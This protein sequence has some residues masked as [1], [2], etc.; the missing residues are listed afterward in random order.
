MAGKRRSAVW[1]GF[2]V[3]G[4][5]AEKPAP[6][7]PKSVEPAPTAEIAA[8]TPDL[9]PVATPSGVFAVG[10][11]SR[12]LELSDTILGW[13]GLP[14]GLR[15]ILPERT[16]DLDRAVAWDA[17]LE[18]ALVLSG[19]ST[20]NPVQA[21]V[22][23]G[24]RSVEA[25]KQVATERGYEI[26][27]LAPGVYTV[28]AIKGASCAIAPALG[29]ASARLVCAS[30]RSELEEVVPY[31]TRGLPN[32]R[33][34]DHDLD[35]ELRFEPVRQKFG[36]MLSKARL[37]AGFLI[38][39]VAID[40][41]RF[42]SALSDATYGLADEAIAL[43]GD[44]DV[45]RAEGTLKRDKQEIE[46][47]VALR[48]RQKNSF[49]AGLVEASA[50]RAGPAPAAFFRMPADAT[51]GGFSYNVEPARWEGVRRVVGELVDAYLEHAKVRPQ[52]RQNARQL[53]ETL[54]ELSHPGTVFADGSSA[55]P[56]GSTA[57]GWSVFRSEMPVAKA[58]P[59]LAQLH[60][61]LSDRTL[62]AALAKRLETNEKALPTARLGRLTGAG[63]PAGTQ[64][65]TVG[66]PSDFRKQVGD[67]VGL[68]IASSLTPGREYAIAIVADQ[69]GSLIGVAPTE[70]EL[71]ALLGPIVTGKGK[72]FADR[73]ELAP[74]REIKA[75]GA[76]FTTVASL[77]QELGASQ[78][79]LTRA[80]S[81][82]PNHG[83]QPIVM[84]FEAETA[85]AL[86]G[87]VRVTVPSGVF[88]D[89]P[90]LLPLAMEG[91]GSKFMKK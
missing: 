83:R 49:T 58:R 6:V 53:N 45:L 48:F 74:L 80:L 4:C 17:P 88:A 62:R 30:R 32:E 44:L 25:A 91:I 29:S 46:L 7:V 33:F 73:P 15:E 87:K 39:R 61:L 22:S 57:S 78:T 59:A 43:V 21:F 19:S 81:T 82:L 85:P 3:L 52:L 60:A 28:G 41:P 10:R 5:A 51:S 72:T 79:E 63:I 77:A 14:V 24:L 64:V 12:A 11:L 42:D 50:G 76:R 1:L 35:F 56:A 34:G 90:G 55:G 47:D 36:G 89:L 18:F 40:V 37:F 75:S 67:Q 69:N 86:V 31:A 38:P 27:R 16:R 68:D 26:E 23:V 2:A 54:F 20:K 71:A 13:A 70:K 9:S 65:V 8:E 84:R 66:V